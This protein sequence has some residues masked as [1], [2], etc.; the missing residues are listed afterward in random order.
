MKRFERSKQLYQ[1]VF[2]AA[3]LPMNQ[4]ESLDLPRIKPCVDYLVNAGMGPGNAIYVSLGAGG[5]AMMLDKEERK[6]AAEAAVEAAAG[7]IPVFV[8]VSSDC[9]ATTVELAKHADRIGADGLQVEPPWYFAGMADDVFG[10]Y[11]AVS[12]AVEIGITAYPTPWTSH[13]DMNEAFV[14]RLATLENVIGLKWYSP[15]PNVALGVIRQFRDRFNIVSNLPG[16]LCASWFIH[17]VHGYVSQG[18]NFMPRT[19]L[20]ILDHLRGKRYE[21]ATQLYMTTEW[22][23]YQA[24]ADCIRQ[25]LNGEANFI[26]ASMELIGY[27]CG[28]A[29]LPLRRPPA[30]FSERV[31]KMLTAAGEVA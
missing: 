16:A 9:T 17:G 13:F 25:G 10:Y 31:G 3:V 7:R 22:E 29:R 15:N 23:Y 4:D 6:A 27:P 26:K 18:V 1:G 24:M 5:E 20:R 14:E 21:E 19:H 30:A 11:R 2:I 8:G 12:D 28:P